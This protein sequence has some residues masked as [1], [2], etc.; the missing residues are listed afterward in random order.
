M[1]MSLHEHASDNTANPGRL[2]SSHNEA[3]PTESSLPEGRKDVYEDV[4]QLRLELDRLRDQQTALQRSRQSH[5][6]DVGND[7]E[8]EQ[9]DSRDR[10]DS[11]A[12]A[13]TYRRTVRL[14]LALVAATL[15]CVAGLRLW[16]YMQSYEWTDD[17]EID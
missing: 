6:T 3:S 5:E 13:H 10:K 11:P 7:A 14:I 2:S 4:R 15:L 12:G 17:A 16:N 9:A 1:E 8:H